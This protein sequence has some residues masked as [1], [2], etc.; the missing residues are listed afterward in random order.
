M[1]K[2]LCLI[3]SFVIL[4]SCLSACSGYNKRMRDHLSD[5]ENYQTIDVVLK[6]IYYQDP[7]T[8]DIVY[9]FDPAEISDCNIVFRVTDE[10]SLEKNELIFE[11]T[12]ENHRILCEN[13]FYEKVSTGEEITIKATTWIY[14]DGYFYFIASVEHDGVV[15]LDFEEGLKNITQMMKKNKSL[16]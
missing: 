13:G 11:V 16:I 12:P 6:D 14:M 5:S 7:K 9:D 3:F 2:L 8:Y 4:I 10:S 1:K 15:Y